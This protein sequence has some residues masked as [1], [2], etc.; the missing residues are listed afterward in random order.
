MSLEDGETPTFYPITPRAP[1]RF[2]QIGIDS[3]TTDIL[4]Q[5]FTHSLYVY[6]GETIMP[7]RVLAS[8]PKPCGGNNLLNIKG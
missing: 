3:H 6:A 2:H 4:H 5:Y 8:E 1:S 7:P